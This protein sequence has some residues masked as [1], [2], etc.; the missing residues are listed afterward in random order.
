MGTPV[1]KNSV[2]IFGWW[3][4]VSKGTPPFDL[5]PPEH[6]DR[7]VELKFAKRCLK[8][9]AIRLLSPPERRNRKFARVQ[10]NDQSAKMGPHVIEGAAGVLDIPHPLEAHLRSLVE[11]WAPSGAGSYCPL[12]FVVA[13]QA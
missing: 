9:F 6:A 7:L 13:G 4:H 11:G 8:G 3:Q 2:K 5:C 10:V 1:S 12:V